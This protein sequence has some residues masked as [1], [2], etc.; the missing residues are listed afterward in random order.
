MPDFTNTFGLEENLKTKL[1]FRWNLY[2][3][4]F[5]TGR[6]GGFNNTK[7]HRT[8]PRL[9]SSNDL[10]SE[11]LF[12]LSKATR[13][14]RAR[15]GALVRSY[16]NNYAL[17]IMESNRPRCNGRS[18]N[19]MLLTIKLHSSSGPTWSKEGVETQSRH[20]F[21]ESLPQFSCW[22]E[23]LRETSV[24]WRSLGSPPSQQE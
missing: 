6:H 24:S 17:F 20:H 3:S 14:D 7:N 19:S 9:F 23:H 8:L 11:R 5:K 4:V 22:H 15:P 13:L 10:G 21:A 18:Q 2:S 16:A 12:N 1:F